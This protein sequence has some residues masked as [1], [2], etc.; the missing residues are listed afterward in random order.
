MADFDK[1]GD[2]KPTFERLSIEEC[3]NV[4]LRA[5]LR[6]FLPASLTA[7][8]DVSHTVVF[9]TARLL[10]QCIV[11]VRDQSGETHSALS[12]SLSAIIQ[13]LT[14]MDQSSGLQLANAV[15]SRT[16]ITAWN[17]IDAVAISHASAAKNAQF[18]H[19]AS[20]EDVQ[21][22]S[23]YDQAINVV[24]MASLTDINSLADDIFTEKLWPT[25]LDAK[26][27]STQG[28][29]FNEYY[30][31]TSFSFWR[32]WYQGFLDGKPLD[33]EL[34][35]RVA[36]I[37]DTIWDEGAEAVARE[38]ERIKAEFLA[39][40]L[41]LAET[42]ELNP[43]SGKFRAIPLPVVKTDLLGATLLQVEDALEDVLAS[44]SNGLH[45]GSREIRVLRR[46]I[47]KYGN[48]PQ[49]IEMGFVSAHKGLLRQILNDELPAS[50]ENIALQEALAEGARGIRA[51]HPDVAEN[52]K[53]L[54]E[55]A[56]R[57]LPESAQEQLRDAL[58]V[59]VA[60]SDP[61]LADDWQHDIPQLINDATL[62]LPSGAPA[63]PGA[64]EATRIFYRA[65]KISLLLKTKDII[66]KIDG[67]AGYKAARILLTVAGLVTLGLAIL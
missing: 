3:L 40:K 42:I 41:P 50:E 21:T 24:A 31:S 56:I 37:A 36:L 46:A 13:M 53:I 1:I 11:A 6:D 38:I 62:P 15:F 23:A 7:N 16:T 63:L 33:W 26:L 8:R 34:Q 64:D 44:P 25:G 14:L 17:V 49:Q 48:N 57:E 4:A 51:T 20:P 59:L 28:N 45:E 54:S 43:D 32:D 61:D 12:L 65:A 67:S 27:A 47:G 58:P 60:I 10:L 9:P 29:I 66:H 22:R 35:L 2:L 55:Q 5:A 30:T 19:A 18:M 52:R 39:E